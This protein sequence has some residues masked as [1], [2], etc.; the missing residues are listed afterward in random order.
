M[1]KIIF[2]I[3]CLLGIA[4]TLCAQRIEYIDVQGNGI[5]KT[6]PKA[7]EA[8]IIQCVSQVNG[9]AIETQSQL[10]AVEYISDDTSV[11]SE[12][13]QRRVASATRGVVSS[14][15]II[16]TK[17]NDDGLIEA[18]V[19]AKISK[20]KKGKGADR[21]RIA[22]LPFYTSKSDF[23]VAGESVQSGEVS[24]V[25]TQSFVNRM[26][27]TR[28]FTVLDREYA[29]SVLQ[30]K[31]T[32]AKADTPMEEMCKFGQVLGADY[33]V[34][35]IVESVSS[36]NK[37]VKMG[38]SGL[39]ATV[40]DSGSAITLRFID[41]ATRQ[42]KFSG[43]INSKVKLDSNSQSPLLDI[44]NQFS[45]QAI[46]KV[47]DNIYPLRVIAVED[48]EVVLNQGGDSIIEGDKYEMFAMGD[49]IRDPYTKESLGRKETK[50]GVIEIIRVKGKTS[51]GKILGDYEK[52]KKIFGEK[53]IVCRLMKEKAA[54]QKQENLSEKKDVIW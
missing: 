17:K 47:M 39:E 28:K 38:M 9:L 14:Y 11:S 6:E 46:K 13:F 40:S 7:V 29:N 53:E 20:Y 15:K 16:S 32:I 52:I 2:S 43:I 31:A 34:V 18:V 1:K 3:T 12:L 24:R 22:V 41:I 37:K 36:Q 44:F 45:E 21:L 49:I 54:P 8:A 48:D 26:V 10:N 35:G 5:G 51:D 23:P 27:D 33:I 30:E 25:A 50:C 42:I 19:S 4:L